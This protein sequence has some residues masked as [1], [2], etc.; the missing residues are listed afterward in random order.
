MTLH[1]DACA[2]DRLKWLKHHLR[3]GPQ[4]TLDA[5][6]GI[7]LFTLYAAK[8]G[9]NV[10]GLSFDRSQLDTAETCRDLLGLQNASFKIC[11]LREL[12][13]SDIKRGSYDQIICCEVIEHILDDQKLIRDLSAFLKPGGMIFLTT[14]FKGNK[15]LLGDYISSSEDGGHVRWGYTHDEIRELF[16]K[17]HLDIVDT[18]YVSGIISQKAAN[19]WRVLRN[20]NG[21][22][23]RLANMLY[24]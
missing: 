17:V 12:D 3:K 10:L 9:N 20:I 24:R 14:P 11:D 7:G 1:A 2:Y 13:K 8:R 18:S 15:G 16:K 5:G 19:A 23:S 6:C 21:P 22:L 4:N